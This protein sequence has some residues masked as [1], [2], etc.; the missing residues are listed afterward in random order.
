V[1]EQQRGSPLLE[2]NKVSWG[3][4]VSCSYSHCMHVCCVL[5]DKEVDE[6]I[7][8][9]DNMIFELK[10]RIADLEYELKGQPSSSLLVYNMCVHTWV[11]THRR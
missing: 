8:S 2:E 10:Q 5:G 7:R 9:R 6:Q 3:D 1:L 4:S 11:Y